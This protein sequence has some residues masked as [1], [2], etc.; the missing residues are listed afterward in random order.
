MRYRKI[1][2]SAILIAGFA[3]RLFTLIQLSSTAFYNPMLMDKHDQK[4]FHLWAQSIQKHP[5]YVDGQAFY[6]A[7]LYPYFL[8]LVYSISGGSIFFAGLLQGL[9][10]TLV[11][12]MIYLLGKKIKDE[13]TGVFAAFFF[14][15]YQTVIL[16]S[17]SILSDGLI[18][19]LNILFITVLYRSLQV[20]TRFS[21]FISGIV[22][23]FAALAKPTIL[24]FIPFIIVGLWLW[25][26]KQLIV[27]SGTKNRSSQLIQA[28]LFG[29]IGCA[30][31]IL[32]VTLRNLVVSREFVLI[33][34]NGPVNWQIGNSSDSVGLFC[35]PK[36]DLLHPASI[37]FWKLIFKKTLL[38]FN[39]YEW[40]QNLS[41]YIAREIV[42]AL[43]LAFVRF[44]FIVSLGVIGIFLAARSGKNFLF[45]SFTIVQIVWVIMF[46][47]TDRYRFP[48]VACLTITAGFLI[49]QTLDEFTKDRKLVKPSIRFILAGLWAYIFGWGPGQSFNDMYWKIFAKLSK[50]NIVYNL[51][52][53][54]N[55]LA[56]KIA[57]DYE[58]LLTQDPDS[59]FFLACVYAQ[60]GKMDDAE[61]ELI[62]T[63]KMNPEHQY[64]RKFL[65][66]IR[67]K[68]L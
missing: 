19:F 54:N 15:F 55:N 3:L 44:G 37:D 8:A 45:V 56:E 1:I 48:A 67:K 2:I 9:L 13:H 10:D 51:Q 4:T 46:F 25:P 6:M 64:A 35:Y 24:A 11:I 60:K 17:V 63:L 33:C 22:L 29:C 18:V 62:I 5:F 28:I 65:D 20:K 43:K 30:I 40:P 12:F 32:P 27:Q 47:I 57:K 68:P 34:T 42:P 38:F 36:G 39:S 61:R 21:Y 50:A 58:K 26:E 53:K 41:I 16:Y 14:A 66:D 52:A 7:P 59:H 49:K 31:I 23:G